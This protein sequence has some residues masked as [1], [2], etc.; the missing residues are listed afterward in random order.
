[1]GTA[2]GI[3][4]RDPDV[5]DAIV[6][7]AFGRF[8]AIDARFSTFHAD[9]EVS[10]YGRGEVG[11][12]DLSD[13]LREVLGLCEAVR[14]RSDGVFDIRRHRSDGVVDPSGLVKGWAVEEAAAILQ[15]SGARN[16]TVNAGG[17]IVVRG[18]PAPGRA[19]RVGIQ[20]PE[21]RDAMAAI[22][23]VRDLA[24]ATSGA[25]ERG[26]H[27]IDARSGDP[28]TDL[29]SATVVGPSLTFADAYATVA[30]ALGIEGIR[31]VA[32][33]PGY[34]GCVMT[35]DHRFIWTA[36]FEPLLVRTGIEGPTKPEPEGAMAIDG[37]VHDPDHEAP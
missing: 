3:D 4:V 30:F 17:D 35:T 32:A 20:H 33:L 21:I 29:L 10:R 23:D 1:M 15:G 9:S 34:E 18:E 6:D 11:D 12:G 25:Y 2:V 37:T 36:G 31:W 24:V 16:F 26:D 22:L 14:V 19:W 27:V 8:R 7:E 5:R 28:P 13:E